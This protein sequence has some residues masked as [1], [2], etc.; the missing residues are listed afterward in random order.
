VLGVQNE[1]P[2]EVV[3]TKAFSDPVKMSEK[4]FQKLG[5]RVDIEEVQHPSGR[6]VVFQIPSRP[7]GTAYHLDG[8]YLMRC[9]EQLIPMSED[10][11]R[12]IFKEGE[13]NWLEE[14]SIA[15]LKAEEVVELL[16][17]DGF[18]QLLHLPPKSHLAS[19]IDSLLQERLIDEE[20]DSPFDDSAR[21][22][23]LGIYVNSMTFNAKPLA[24]SYTPIL[25]RRKQLKLTV[26][27]PKGTR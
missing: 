7:T 4:L 22:C 10:Q 1:P 8:K 18:F 25:P 2:R 17:T 20:N 3:G 26:P 16:D 23:W 5:F 14:H 6:V 19:V 27:C 13:P 12:K 24:S 11:L 9:G 15:G 21:F